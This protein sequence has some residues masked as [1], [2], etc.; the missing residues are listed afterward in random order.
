MQNLT[1]LIL[2][3]LRQ[4]LPEMDAEAILEAFED[5]HPA[6]V[7][8]IL[9]N[10]DDELAVK[11]VETLP[12]GLSVKAFEHLEEPEQQRLLER[13]GR[14]TMIK[15]IE[16]MSSD[17]RVDLLQMLPE[18]TVDSILPLL[19]QAERNDIKNLLSHEEG[20]A[21]AVMTTEYASVPSE[22]TV[23]DALSQLR[24]IAPER[25]TIYEIFVIDAERHLLGR[26]GL[27]R[28][29]LARPDDV[30]A[31]IMTPPPATCHVGDD[32][33]D[34]ARSIEKYDVLA[35]PVLDAEERLVGI[36]TQD[37]VIDVIEEEATEDAHRMGG[38][39]PLDVPYFQE[40]FFDLAKKR[41][42]WLS[43]LFIGGM[44]TTTAMGHYSSVLESL[45]F[46]MMFLPI[47]ISSGGN[48]GSQSATLITRGLAVGDVQLAD[49]GRIVR[50]ELLMGMSLGLMLAPVGMLMARLLGSPSWFQAAIGITL[51]A[52]V[53]AGSIV[54]ACLPLITKRLGFDPAVSST[55]F[56]S[57]LVDVVGIVIYIN[58]ARALWGS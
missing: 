16:K 44:L 43:M 58:I 28:L 40:G 29:V 35:L 34:V 54:G 30:V 41:V 32:Q 13:L 50:R 27:R 6:D 48:T 22:M 20:T 52:V 47:I 55:P 7:A 38:V 8:D 3:D 4:M 51:V 12:I 1:H 11:V 14:P 23:K 39:A 53:T 49:W 21:G 36:V 57:S 37:D 56:V 2:P 31:D 45:S 17:D 15:L 18:R 24:K 25:E 9:E 42:V 26:L 5:F 33:E 46:V 10:V 19:A